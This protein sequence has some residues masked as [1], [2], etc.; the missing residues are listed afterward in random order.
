MVNRELLNSKNVKFFD[1][2]QECNETVFVPSG[3]YHQVVNVE[4]T[5]SVNHNWFNGCNVAVVADNLVKHFEDV[6]KEIEDCRDMENFSEHCQLMM[7][8]SFGMNFKDFFDIIFHIINKRIESLTHN[9]MTEAFDK[10][11]FG[12]NHILS[13]L[14]IISKFLVDLVKNPSVAQFK[15]L[16][17]ESI[18]RIV[19][20][21]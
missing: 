10:F 21:L 16:M 6:V 4:D 2:I 7:K 18:K 19:E 11:Y 15:D 1:F 13:D 14:K 8:S 17:E 20:V 9:N 3:W 12:R 5:V